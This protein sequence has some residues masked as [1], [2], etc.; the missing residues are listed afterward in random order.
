M[1]GIGSAQRKLPLLDGEAST[2]F[3]ASIEAARINASCRIA[4]GDGSNKYSRRRKSY[5]TP[6]F[7]HHRRASS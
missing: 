4:R 2:Q 3:S 7:K 6:Q 5:G 1:R